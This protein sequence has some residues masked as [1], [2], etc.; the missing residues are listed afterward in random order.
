MSKTV[1]RPT[2]V[3]RGYILG[4]AGFAKICAIEG[5]HRKRR[6]EHTGGCGL[7]GGRAEDQAAA[8]TALGA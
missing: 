4:R 7:D 2:D 3:K 1:S 8:A 5:I 6:R